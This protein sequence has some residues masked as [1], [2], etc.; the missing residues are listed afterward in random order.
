MKSPSNT[1]FSLKKTLLRNTLMTSILAGSLSFLL[2]IVIVIWEQHELF[3]DL[4]QQHAQQILQ[5]RHS[6]KTLHDFQIQHRNAQNDFDSKLALIP[7]RQPE[8]DIAKW[9]Y[10]WQDGQLWRIYKQDFVFQNQNYQLQLAQNVRERYEFLEVAFFNFAWL[11]PLLIILLGLGNYWAIRRSLLVFHQVTEQIA[12]KHPQDLSA[13]QP[14]SNIDE[15][16]PMLNSMNELLV[17]LQQALDAE[18]RFTANAAHELRTP[19]AAIQMKLQLLQR[20]HHETLL[21]MQADFQ[22]LQNDVKRSTAVVENLLLLARLDPNQPLPK[23]QFKLADLCDEVYRSVLPLAEPQDIQ[24]IQDWQFAP[25]FQVSAN[26]ELLFTAIRNLLDNAI[27]Y[28]QA[29]QEHARQIIFMVK[30]Q[31]T[32]S[33]TLHISIL[34]NGPGVSPEQQQHLTQRFYRVLGTGQQGS[35]LGLSIVQQIIHLHQGKLSFSSGIEGLGLGVNLVM[36][37]D[38]TGSQF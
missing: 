36:P 31:H 11:M 22:A 15:L 17:R 27:R 8:F 13:I 25:D 5:Q 18:Q 26:R 24:L 28:H 37:A 21:P 19:L 3:D 12:S 30:I 29:T 9:D 10:S 34:D 23:S 6:V 38:I 14:V 7:Q 16:Q 32:A 20:R 1:H 35:G 33:P 4:L 2:V